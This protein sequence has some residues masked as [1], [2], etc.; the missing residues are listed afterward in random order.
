MQMPEYLRKAV[1]DLKKCEVYG[2][3]DM[4]AV[5]FFMLLKEAYEKGQITEE[6]RE[7]LLENS[8]NNFKNLEI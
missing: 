5:T 2:A 3:E 6:T 4:L 8:R 1:V 7:I